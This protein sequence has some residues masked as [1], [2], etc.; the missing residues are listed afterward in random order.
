VGS[1]ILIDTEA[2]GFGLS[3][4]LILTFAVTSALLLFFLIGLALKSYRRPVVS[5]SEELMGAVGQAV[6][7]FPGAGSIHL[8]GEIWSARSDLPIAPGTPVEVTGRDGLTL[9]IVPRTA[10]KGD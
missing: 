7:G 1:L 6:S 10:D 3:I 4:R 9:L 8:H 2:P 5:G